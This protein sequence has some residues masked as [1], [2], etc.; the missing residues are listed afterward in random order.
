MYSNVRQHPECPAEDIIN[1]DIALDGWF[2]FQN[3]KSEKEKKKNALLDKIGGNIRD[4][5]DHVFIMTKDE[6]EAKSIHDLNGPEEKQFIKEVSEYA[7]KHPDTRWE[8]IPCVKRRAI[9]E[10]QQKHAMSKK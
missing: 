7:K 2:I 1:D 6:E 4:K 5:A 9:V 3:R 8:D 10:A